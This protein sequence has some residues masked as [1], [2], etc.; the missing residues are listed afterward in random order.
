MTYA[1]TTVESIQQYGVA[2][3][4]WRFI[5]TNSINFDNNTAT[6]DSNRGIL[7]DLTG[8]TLDFPIK[9]MEVTSPDNDVRRI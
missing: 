7:E 1:S 2:V 9:R 5:F 6:A 4:K 3:V 8:T